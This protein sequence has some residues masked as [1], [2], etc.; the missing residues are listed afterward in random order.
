MNVIVQSKTLVITEAIRAF[1]EREAEKLRRRGQKISQV[2]VFLEKV[3]RKKNDVQAAT[4]K[5]LIEL[6]GKQVVVQHKAQD[7]YL[8]IS[9][10]AN[11]ATLQVRR[12][13]EKR[14]NH[15]PHHFQKLSWIG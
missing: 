5:F 8:A 6:P 2:T 14:V 11:R 12:F 4:A 10:A 15:Y 7:L 3:A 9:E 13:R 1:A